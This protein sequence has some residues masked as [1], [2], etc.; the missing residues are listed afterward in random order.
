MKSF[1]GL[2]S[3]TGITNLQALVVEAALLLKGCIIPDVSQLQLAAMVIYIP[4]LHSDWF[5]KWKV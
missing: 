2:C 3:L 4:M 1:F 5:T